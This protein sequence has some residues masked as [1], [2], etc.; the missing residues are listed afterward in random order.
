MRNKYFLK[1]ASV[2]LLVMCTITGA[3]ALSLSRYATASKLK[4]GRW[5]KIQIPESGIYELTTAELSEMGFSDIS[6]VRVYGNGGY[7]QSEVLDGSMPDD[8]VQVPVQRYGDKIC[9]YAKGPVSIKL[10]T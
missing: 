10:E 1:L 2:V 9:F 5:V 3:Q 8:L 6:K 4:T 7:Q